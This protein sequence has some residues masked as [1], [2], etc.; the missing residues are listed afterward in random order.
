MEEIKLKIN[1]LIFELN[2]NVPKIREPHAAVLISFVAVDLTDICKV[3][4]LK[5]SK[6]DFDKVQHIL[7]EHMREIEISRQKLSPVDKTYLG[8]VRHRVNII[9]QNI[10]SVYRDRTVNE[11]E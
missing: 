10:N 3:I 5:M 9:F 1:T 2:R 6:K 7:S 4:D 8:D 11:S